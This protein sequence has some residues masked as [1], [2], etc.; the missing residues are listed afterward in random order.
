MMTL[1][2]LQEELDRLKRDVDE[3]EAR[4]AA[5]EKNGIL[6]G[7]KNFAYVFNFEFPPGVEQDEF[8]TVT[9][10]P[11]QRKTVQVAKNTVFYVKSMAQAY[12]I[13]GTRNDETAQSALLT[14]PASQMPL[15]FDFKF[16]INDTGSDMEWQNDWVPGQALLTGNYNSFRFRKGHRPCSP[17]A[18]VTIQVQARS[19]GNLS[20]VTGLSE[21][22]NQRLQI[23]LAG[24]EVPFKEGVS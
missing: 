22:K 14:I 12:T 21:I 13:T 10:F 11:L 4:I 24:F 9:N 17:G 18:E 23:V 3:R 1:E 5:F 6:P 19:F 15:I 20:S 16:K 8:L 2:Q 7:E